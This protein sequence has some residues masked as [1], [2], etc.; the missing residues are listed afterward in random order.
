MS[1]VIVLYQITNAKDSKESYNAFEIPRTTGTVTLTDV[2][3]HCHA[4]NRLNVAGSSGY[5][6]RV[7]VDDKQSDPKAPAKYSWWDIQDES[8]RLPVKEISSYEVSRMLSP[9]SAYSIHGSDESK[10][11]VMGS[12]GKAMNKVALSVESSSQAHHDM[13]P[14]VPII[15]FK[16][17]DTSKLYDEFSGKASNNVHNVSQQVP[18]VAR[19]SSAPSRSS[20]AQYQR[21]ATAP[22][23]SQHVPPTTQILPAAQARARGTSSAPPRAPPVP[24]V[25]EATLVDFGAVSTPKP[26]TALHR[27][28]TSTSATGRAPNETRA[29]QLKREYEEKN[30]KDNRVWD[31]VDHRWVSVDASATSQHSSVSAPPGADVEVNRS[32]L[33]G[34]SLDNVN[35]EGKSREVAAAVQER[36][37]DMKNA[38]QKALDEIREREEAKKMAENE[39]DAVRQKLEPKIKA[40]S[41]EHGK[42]KQLRALLANL[43]TILWSGAN[44]KPLGL[45][46]LLDDKKVKLAFHKASRVVHPDKTISLGPEERFLAKRIFD[47]LSQAKSELDNK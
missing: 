27:S 7:R 11:G 28:D 13:G 36:V 46:D 18:A 26:A 30:R 38:Q 44:W 10:G 15:I 1:K 5:H 16:L 21:Q 9:P 40:W 31:D 45:G 14:K 35:L 3:N 6:W 41:E 2:K 4:L 33:K 8:A 29:Q 23:S 43:H 12:I 42:K 39:E 47:A 24:N 19:Q 32:N 17:L 25:Q 22:P 34:V 37:A 20:Q